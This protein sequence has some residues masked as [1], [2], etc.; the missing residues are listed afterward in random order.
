M[1]FTILIGSCARKD[2]GPTSDVDIIRVGHCYTVTPNPAYDDRCISYIDFTPE[3]FTCLY[4]QGSLFLHHAFT[5]GILVE[6]SKDRWSHL[7]SR[8]VVEQ[9]FSKPILEY[10]NL[11]C[12][13][14]SK[15][16]YHLSYMPYLSNYCKYVK[17]I[18]IFK[19]AQQRAYSYDKIT[20]MTRGCNLST[21]TS[22]LLRHA[23]DSF[24]RGYR[25]ED[26]LF[27][28]LKS[29]ARYLYRNHE[30]IVKQIL[31]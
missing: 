21:Q 30:H 10:T 12:Y 24:E 17:N 19:L 3:Q 26:A 18:G 13:L 11:L 8:F 2:D 31:R 6:G 4:N 20:A 25:F 14:N 15:H 9:D 5:E 29:L 16:E 22:V 28:Q 1:L 23:Y 7:E 27:S